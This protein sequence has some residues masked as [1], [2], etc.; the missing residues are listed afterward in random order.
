MLLVFISAAHADLFLCCTTWTFSFIA[1]V[2]AVS[3][4]IYLGVK[5]IKVGIGKN[6][7]LITGA[8]WAFALIL[9]FT[10][11]F[12]GLVMAPP[13]D[14]IRKIAQREGMSESNITKMLNGPAR[15]A[16]TGYIIRVWV[17]RI[18]LDYLLEGKVR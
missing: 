6:K 18:Y 14:E 16:T 5:A 1:N 3:I 10:P 4:V 2:I 12:L 9:L 7:V 8:I 15:S 17:W 13:E 11:T